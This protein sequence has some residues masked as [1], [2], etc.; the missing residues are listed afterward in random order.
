MSS[1]VNAR[2]S[3]LISKLSMLTSAISMGCVGLLVT[4]LSGFPIYTIVLLRGIFGTFFLTLFMVKSRSFN[5]DFLKESFRL[6]WK[7][8]LIIGII[9]PIVIYLYFVNIT[10]SGYAIA[11]FLLYT[12]GIFMLT[13]VI[14]SRIEEVSKITIVSFFLAIIGVAC[15]MEFW[16]GQITDGLLLGLLSGITLAVLTFSKKVIYVKRQDKPDE[17]KTKGDFDLFL[18]WFPTLFIIIL[19]LPLGASDL[20]N[21]TWIDLIFALI[22]GFFPTALAFT[23]YNIGVKNDKG[24]NIIILAFFEPVVASILAIIILQTISIYTIIGGSLILIANI[25]VLKYSTN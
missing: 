21:L 5:L 12:S 10:I 4:L 9:N 19:F 11:A 24:G 7:P 22:L 17:I 16:T 6:H 1:A 18:A 2:V 8:L 13:F 3:P 23:L 14:I 20:V 15:I 25:I